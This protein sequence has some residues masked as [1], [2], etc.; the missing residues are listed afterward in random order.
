[1]WVCTA[2]AGSRDLGSS[3]P[4]QHRLEFLSETKTV[5]PSIHSDKCV[6]QVADSAV[7]HGDGE[8]Q[9]TGLGL[10]LDDLRDGLVE[11]GL[12]HEGS[13]PLAHRAMPHPA[14]MGLAQP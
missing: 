2:V 5:P 11:S 6:G 4:A 3:H 8:E 14:E 9:P 10:Y 1:M 12:P 7:A 13:P